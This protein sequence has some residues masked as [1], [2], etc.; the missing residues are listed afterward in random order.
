M[1]SIY[2][3]ADLIIMALI[4]GVY[5]IKR[6]IAGLKKVE[7]FIKFLEIVL[8]I[9]SPTN[10]FILMMNQVLKALFVRLIPLMAS[11]KLLS[12]GLKIMVE[13][14]RKMASGGSMPEIKNKIMP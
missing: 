4:F 14:I 3:I 12:K 6:L 9:G 7:P 10:L 5:T 8:K 13:I 1:M 2:Y 11:M